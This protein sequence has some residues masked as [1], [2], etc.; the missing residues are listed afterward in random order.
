MD[1][2]LSLATISASTTLYTIIPVEPHT[3]IHTCRRQFCTSE[4]PQNTYADLYISSSILAVENPTIFEQKIPYT[5]GMLVTAFQS[6]YWN[7]SGAATVVTAYH[8]ARCKL[9]LVQMDTT[10]EVLMLFVVWHGR[11]FAIV[12]IHY[13]AD[14]VCGSCRLHPPDCRVAHV[15][16]HC[17]G[18]PLS[19]RRSARG[20][21]GRTSEAV[22]AVKVQGKL[23]PSCGGEW[24]GHKSRGCSAR[25]RTAPHC[26]DRRQRSA[27]CAA[28]SLGMMMLSSFPRPNFSSQPSPPQQ[29][30][31]T[32]L[33][34]STTRTIYC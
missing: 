16:P 1:Y 25:L 11:N 20:R 33:Q 6:P 28:R 12:A 26:A 21:P 7:K 9:I 13:Q 4:L 24:K 31:T 19:P 5:A 29:W 2:C 15:N 14:D 23:Q 27:P 18:I 3:I 10:G 32:P 34:N 17:S 8:I 22:V 30:Q